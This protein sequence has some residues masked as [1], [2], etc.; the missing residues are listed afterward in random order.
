[1]SA[2]S[3]PHTAQSNLIELT[4]RLQKS[5]MLLH[6]NYVIKI[7]YRGTTRKNHMQEIVIIIM[8]SLGKDEVLQFICEKRTLLELMVR[9]QKPYTKFRGTIQ[10]HTRQAYTRSAW[11]ITHMPYKTSAWYITHMPQSLLKHHTTPRQ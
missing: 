5:S 7:I 9:E 2:S 1:V 4:Y 6:R 8:T 3:I 10:E 11:Y